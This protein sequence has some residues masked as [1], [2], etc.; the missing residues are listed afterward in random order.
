MYISRG[1][2]SVSILLNGYTTPKILDHSLT[3]G[4]LDGVWKWWQSGVWGVPHE[5]FL[6]LHLKI[7][8][9]LG[10]LSTRLLIAGDK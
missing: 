5:F 9:I 2:D 10:I 3:A 4:L 8:K 7:G 1:E 6:E